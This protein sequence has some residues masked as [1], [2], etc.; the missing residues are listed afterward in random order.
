MALRAEQK[1]SLAHIYPTPQHV[2]LTR[3]RRVGG[4]ASDS[5]PWARLMQDPTSELPRITLPKLSDNS[6]RASLRTPEGAQN[7]A[8]NAIFSPSV[9]PN[10]GP[11]G[12]PNDLS[13]SFSTHL[14]G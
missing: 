13:D 11:Q 4:R 2:V 1:H 10:V 12:Y 7:E 14:G 9:S 6:T 5:V 8:G 3:M